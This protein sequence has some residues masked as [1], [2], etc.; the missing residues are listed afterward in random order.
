MTVFF[1]S[2]YERWIR[3]HIDE[4]AGTGYE[5]II[6]LQLNLDP[7]PDLSQRGPRGA[8]IWYPP[9]HLPERFKRI[10]LSNLLYPLRSVAAGVSMKLG[11]TL[12]F[13]NC[14]A[15]TGYPAPGFF[16]GQYWPGIYHVEVVTEF[17]L[18]DYPRR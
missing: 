6:E 9:P 17:F 4:R 3:I 15:Y 10:F 7:G 13:I 8:Y 5:A 18:P 1:L 12:T 14:A 16:S 11:D 2:I